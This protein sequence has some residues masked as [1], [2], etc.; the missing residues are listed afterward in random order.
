MKKTDN[1]INDNLQAAIIYIPKD[2]I[3]LDITVKLLDTE[4]YSIYE[5]NQVMDIA[6][7]KDAII[8]GEYWEAENVKYVLNPDYAK[9]INDGK[10][11]T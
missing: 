7:V 1:E 6:A 3:A 10:S 4:D 9:E 5:C 8:D 2:A 11:D